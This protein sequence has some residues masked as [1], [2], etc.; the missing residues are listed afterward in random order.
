VEKSR[1]P[2]GRAGDV[3]FFFFLIAGQRGIGGGRPWWGFDLLGKVR[4]VTGFPRCRPVGGGV[5][6]SHTRGMAVPVLITGWGGSSSY[7]TVVS[8][9]PVLY[10]C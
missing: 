6:G 3:F 9:V 4:G 5:Y 8:L 2:A 7:H 1:Q 10:W